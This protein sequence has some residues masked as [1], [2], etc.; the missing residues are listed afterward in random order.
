MEIP[1]V[2]PDDSAGI[3]MAV[4]HLVDLGH[5]RIAHVAGPQTTST[6]VFRSRAFRHAIRDHGLDDDPS[7]VVECDYWTEAE[8]A[9][10]AASAVG[11]GREFTA[12]VAGNDLIALGCYDV[13]AER[14][15][16]CPDDSA[17]SAST[18]CPSSTS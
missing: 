1:S 7:L 9:R 14:G 2:T 4:E 16:S 5:R 8:G 17:W 11:R 15:I 18:T 3:A 6:G 12:I 10:G 13:F